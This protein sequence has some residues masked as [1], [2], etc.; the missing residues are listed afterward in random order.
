MAF[1][2]TTGTLP[3]ENFVQGTGVG[4][5]PADP[6]CLPFDANIKTLI[7]QLW[8]V[9]ENALI[10]PGMYTVS[11]QWA[12]GDEAIAAVR[13]GS[14]SLGWSYIVQP[15]DTA[16]QIAEGLR[17]QMAADA[18]FAS[19]PIFC[20][21]VGNYGGGAS[22][23]ICPPWSTWETEPRIN[24][25][26]GKTSVNGV[27]SIGR[28]PENVLDTPAMTLVQAHVVPGRPAQM[29]DLISEWVAMGQTDKIEGPDDRNIRQI[30]ARLQCYIRNPS[31][32]TPMGRWQFQNA[33]G[34]ENNVQN[35]MMLSDGLLLC[36]ANGQHPA[37]GTGG[38][39]FMGA[40][41]INLPADGGIFRD[42]VKIL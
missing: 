13:W 20:M 4:P 23:H 16:W 40:G 25:T 19:T 35:A 28:Q 18:T 34:N 10:Y 6:T 26:V 21:A 2:F 39:G 14:T 36:D 42:G 37:G 17:N 29:N 38:E 30:Y 11:G 15:N 41:T 5:L 31:N 27:I 22:W 8:L 12:P 1:E 24:L 9:S 3:D 32:A 7:H 33:S